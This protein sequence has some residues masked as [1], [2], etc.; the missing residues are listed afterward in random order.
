MNLPQPWTV[1]GA[2]PLYLQQIPIPKTAPKLTCHIN[3]EGEDYYLRF[4]LDRVS[5]N[6]LHL[7]FLMRRTSPWS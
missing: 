3:L 2:L 4:W 5:Y 1:D 7:R 6:L